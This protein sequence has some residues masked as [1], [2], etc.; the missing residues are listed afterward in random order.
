MMNFSHLK[1]KI[2]GKTKGKCS[3]LR[4]TWAL[5]DGLAH[6]LSVR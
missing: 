3:E 1:V 6:A 2:E 4:E 5:W